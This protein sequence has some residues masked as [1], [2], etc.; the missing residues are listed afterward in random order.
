MRKRLSFILVLALLATN[1]V[2]MAAN[3]PAK[4]QARLLSDVLSVEAIHPDS[5]YPYIQRIEDYLVAS[6]DSDSRSV[7]HLALAR[8]YGERA[9]SAQYAGHEDFEQRSLNHF[10]AAFA[11]W[12]R[13]ERM[14]AKDWRPLVVIGSDDVYEDMLGVAYWTLRQVNDSRRTPWTEKDNLPAD[15]LFRKSYRERGNTSAEMW[16]LIET[17]FQKMQDVKYEQEWLQLLKDFENEPFA[18]ELYL[19]LSRL[20]GQTPQKA[21]DYLEE[22]LRRYP[23]YKYKARLQNDLLQLSDPQFHWTGSTLLYPG[24]TYDWAFEARNVD[25]VSWG[26]DSHAFSLP[27]DVTAVSDTIPWLAPTALGSFKLS[28]LP[29]PLVKTQGKV[30]PLTMDFLV[31]RFQLLCQVLPDN[32][33]QLAVVDRQTGAPMPGVRVELFREDKDTVAYRTLLTGADGRVLTAYPGAGRNFRT[34]YVRLSNA[35]ESGLPIQSVTAG[36]YW[37]AANGEEKDRHI[38]LYTDRAIYRPG[39]ELK[40]NGLVYEQLGWEA[41]VVEGDTL[42]LVLRDQQRKEVDRQRVVSDSLGVFSA[43]FHLPADRRLGRWTLQTADRRSSVGFRVEQYKRPTFDVLLPD[44]LLRTSDSLVVFGRALRY[45]G[46]PLRGA[47][48]TGTY[49]YNRWRYSVRNDQGTPLDTVQTDDLGFFRVSV[50]RDAEAFDFSVNVNV[51]AS[52]GEQQ[53]AY[54]H[55]SL[56]PHQTR[57]TAKEDSTV[58]IECLR[59]T[60]DAQ[61]PALLR[62]STRQDEAWAYYTLAARGEIFLDT[63]LR[64]TCG[65]CDLEIPYDNRYGHGVVASLAVVACERVY[66]HVQNIVL[67]QP[68]IRLRMHWDTFR[69][70]TQP[71]SHEHWQLTLTRPDGSAARNANVMATL[72][73]AS[74]DRLARHP[75]TLNVYRNYNL[76]GTRF[77]KVS[78]PSRWGGIHQIYSQKRHKEKPLVLYSYLDDKWFGS[79]GAMALNGSIGGSPH[80]MFKATRALSYAAAPDAADIAVEEENA[81]T[82]STQDTEQEETQ[83][84]RLEALPVRENFQETAYCIANLRTNAQGQAVMDFTL[85]ESTT[86]WRLQGIAHTSDLMHLAFGEEIVAQKNLMAQLHLPRFVRMGDETAIRVALTNNSDCAQQVRALLQISSQRTGKQLFQKSLNM[87]LEASRD[88]SVVFLYQVKET[89][90]LVVRCTAQGADCTDGEQRLLGVEPEDVEVTNSLP[91]FVEKE[92]NSQYDLSGMFPQGSSDRRLSV[93]YT[94]H[95]DRLALD[96]LPQLARPRGQSAFHIAVALYATRLGQKLGVEVPDS[97]EALKLRLAAMQC[98]DGGISW[99]PGMPSTRFVS[100]EIGC[101]LARL[102]MLTGEQHDQP[103]LTSITRYL[104]ASKH[105]PDALRTLYVVQH[106][107]LRLNEREQ[108]RVDSLVAEVKSLNPEDLGPEDQALC[109]IV[110]KGQGMNAKAKKM[111]EAFLPRLVER[112]NQGTC[113]EWPQGPWRSIDRKLDIHVQMMEALQEVM[114]GASQLPGMRRHLLCQKRTQLWDTPLHSASA[115]FALCRGMASASAEGPADVLTL[116]T[117]DQKAPINLVASNDSVLNVQFSISRPADKLVIQK[118]S[119]GE[120]W[121]SVQATFRQDFTDVQTDTTGLAVRQSL[122]SELKVGQRVAVQHRLMADTDYEFVTLRVPRPAALEPVSQVSGCRWTDGLCYYM[123][124]TDNSILYHI[125]SVPRGHYRLTTDYYV[126]RP[127]SYHTGVATVECSLAPEFQGRD[128][129]YQVVVKE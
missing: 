114:P 45:D 107:S 101:L 127:G 52:Y 81:V 34:L 12:S 36:R 46:M 44:T 23:K 69:D 51:L 118:F 73:D 25:R 116:Y 70:L 82:G 98:S 19:Y 115:I 56:R 86:T 92:G 125:L 18:A 93:Q 17:A 22:G 37:Y 26:E 62:L 128:C 71:G 33:L 50:R 59:D 28:F 24:S 43:D 124:V 16:L 109:A 13:L 102:E 83:E 35:E 77:A 54:H 32:Q 66:T 72:Y 15:S 89:D 2:L 120:S 48:L 60:F 129:D 76:A 84:E 85:P 88:T 1:A 68:D 65:T 113:I 27:D 49:Y 31:T 7:C 5:V 119:E 4:Q 103:M 42:T 75:W 11:N 106:S 121:A 20:Q 99:Y 47:R 96:A 3:K 61:H 41:H 8:L 58:V 40:V 57:P 111:V 67:A 39:Q 80:V 63:L 55:Y 123:E 122:P 90:S 91:I 21:K 14:K 94:V 126:E 95:P 29:Q 64:I 38:Q 97:A 74:L 117:G 110:L 112:P 87:S 79:D 53:E 6:N 30:E 108:H 104:L 9:F 100:L 78:M 105:I 10:R